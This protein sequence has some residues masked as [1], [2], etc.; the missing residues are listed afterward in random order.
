MTPPITRPSSN[1]SE[2]SSSLKSRFS[3]KDSH[4]HRPESDYAHLSLNLSNLNHSPNSSPDPALLH[5]NL[6]LWL[7]L[8]LIS[9]A[10]LSLAQLGAALFLQL[11][12]RTFAIDVI[13]SDLGLVIAHLPTIASV[14]TQ[15]IHIW[16]YAA[17]GL[18]G[19]WLW[20]RRLGR[21]EVSFEEIAAWG[22]LVAGQSSAVLWKSRK[23]GVAVAV[24]YFV[25]LGLGIAAGSAV[26]SAVTLT[27]TNETISGWYSVPSIATTNA[28]DPLPNTF[29]VINTRSVIFD[30]MGSLPQV[31]N[32]GWIQVGGAIVNSSDLGIAN[33]GILQ[34]FIGNSSWRG[35][36]FK[37]Q[38]SFISASLCLSGLASQP[39]CTQ[40]TTLLTVANVGTFNGSTTPNI[41]TLAYTN[42]CGQPVTSHPLDDF[43]SGIPYAS[44]CID[45]NG[46]N[47]IDWIA[48][49]SFAG[50]ASD[51][52]P[53]DQS[54][55]HL[56]CALNLA[57]SVE[58]MTIYRRNGQVGVER[59]F[60]GDLCPPPN[61]TV[62]MPDIAA[63]LNDR[64]ALALR[65]A[66]H[67][68]DF[69]RLVLRAGLAPDGSFAGPD[70][71]GAVLSQASGLAFRALYTALVTT[72]FTYDARGNVLNYK[73]TDTMGVVTPTRETYSVA[74]LGKRSWGLVALLGVAGVAVLGS[75]GLL[76]R[77][78]G[79]FD[80]SDAAA[81]AA[82]A[83]TVA[84]GAGVGPEKGMGEV[85][86]VGL[87]Q[88][89]YQ[90]L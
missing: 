68:D 82:V 50:S 11:S 73:G 42:G 54:K 72:A 51:P 53:W 5:S 55:L 48:T 87:G 41:I 7:K 89:P 67:D 16:V 60:A 77:R 33:P 58:R 4:H 32:L 43:D 71:L 76:F 52:P 86:G 27:S 61:L 26:T 40:A 81:V 9:T 23:I 56:S 13:N 70:A 36:K 14:T 63:T 15:S 20:E 47:F 64:V 8:T 22:G 28:T 65:P 39:V 35:E 37:T 17:I 31:N 6:S 34:S 30:A 38:D 69:Q 79:A 75:L 24:V 46:N 3:L 80:P 84:T 19:M 25:A 2:K 57:P 29:D 62:S 78:V 74:V 49:G 66:A 10:L 18:V 83:V 12:P 90:R 1:T 44:A 88:V 45:G 85:K 21:P 59:S